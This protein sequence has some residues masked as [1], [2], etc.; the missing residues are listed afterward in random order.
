VSGKIVESWTSWDSGSVLRQF[1]RA[2]SLGP[3]RV[4]LLPSALN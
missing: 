2:T 3:G 1:V 4:S